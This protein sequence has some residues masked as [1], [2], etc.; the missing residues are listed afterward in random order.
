MCK[1]LRLRRSTRKKRFVTRDN[2]EIIIIIIIYGMARPK[3][4]NE[5]DGP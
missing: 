3:V 4:A 1:D 5:E 2:I